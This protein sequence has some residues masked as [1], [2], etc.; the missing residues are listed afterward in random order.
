MIRYSNTKIPLRQ[1]AVF[2]LRRILAAAL[3]VLFLIMCMSAAFAA[4]SRA[5]LAGSVLRFHVLANSDS[6][7]DQALKLQ[8]RDE[9]L[10][11]LREA[12]GNGT[13]ALDETKAIVAERLEQLEQTARAAVLREGYD[14]PVKVRLTSLY[15]PEKVCGEEIF[16]AGRYETL[17]VVIGAGEGH[18]WW[19]LLFPADC[20]LE[21]VR[22]IA[23]EDGEEICG[24]LEEAGVSWKNADFH[25]LAKWF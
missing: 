15:F 2:W 18:N 13:N 20:F 22:G 10:S 23:P 1:Q 12:L 14:Y 19:G 8:V 11:I 17:Q 6:S 5:R 16:P 24:V 9:L 3:T 25:I 4:A 7:Q 21:A